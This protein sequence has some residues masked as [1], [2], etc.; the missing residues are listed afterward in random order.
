MRQSST[1]DGWT[2]RSSDSTN[3]NDSAFSEFIYIELI[4]ASLRL[5]S[6]GMEERMDE[7]EALRCVAAFLFRNTFGNPDLFVSF[8]SHSMLVYLNVNFVFQM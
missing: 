8:C 6:E 3:S 2:R 1:D 7:A 5:K 4:S